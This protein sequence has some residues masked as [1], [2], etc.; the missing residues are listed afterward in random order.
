MQNIT[1]IVHT[2]TCT[3]TCALDGHTSLKPRMLNSPQC[4]PGGPR[5]DVR[6]LH[7]LPSGLRAVRGLA[8]DVLLYDGRARLLVVTGAHAQHVVVANLRVAPGG[9]AVGR[10]L[11]SP[12]KS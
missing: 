4:P 9:V 3:C 12:G 8:T 10:A 11:T 6:I 7:P 1:L 2:C 5:R